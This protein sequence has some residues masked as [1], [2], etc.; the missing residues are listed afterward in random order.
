MLATRVIV[1]FRGCSDGAPGRRPLASPTSSAARRWAG[2]CCWWRLP[3]RSLRPTSATA[4]PELRDHAF[5]PGS[6]HLNL[7]QW[8]NGRRTACWRSSSSSPGWSSSASSSPAIFA[9]RVGRPSRSSRQSVAWRCRP[10]CSSLFN[11][12]GA[13][14]GWAIPTATDIAF[15]LAVL[16]VIGSHLPSGTAYVPADPCRG[17]RPDRHHHHR[18]GLHPDPAPAT[19]CCSPSSRSRPSPCSCSDGSARGGCC[20]RWPGSRGRWC[21]PRECTRRSPGCCWRLPC[22]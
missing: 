7:T 18:R 19:T 12:G 1:W 20:F 3:R 14:R 4:T 13:L 9:T 2:C 6:L 16:A 8:R 10:G 11:L 15:A 17:R 5:G 22:R 21:T